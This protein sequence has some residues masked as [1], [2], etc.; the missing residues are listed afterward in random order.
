VNDLDVN[1]MCT[2]IG[3][4]GFTKRDTLEQLVQGLAETVCDLPVY[5]VP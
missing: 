4:G 3:A 5:V 1:V 2:D